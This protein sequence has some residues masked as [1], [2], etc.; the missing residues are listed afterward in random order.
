MVFVCI[1]HLLWNTHLC[2]LPKVEN[3]FFFFLTVY[4]FK[5]S[6]IPKKNIRMVF[7]TGKK[8]QSKQFNKTVDPHSY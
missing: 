6:L 8:Y 1:K 3:P 5:I 2:K 4:N 7:L